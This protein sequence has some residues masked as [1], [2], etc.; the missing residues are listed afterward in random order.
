LFVEET[1]FGEEIQNQQEN[2]VVKM[3]SRMSPKKVIYNSQNKVKKIKSKGIEG[4][5]LFTF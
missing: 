5:F 1:I 2:D 3:S 4:S